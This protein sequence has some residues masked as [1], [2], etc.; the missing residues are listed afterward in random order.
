LLEIPGGWETNRSI[1]SFLQNTLINGRGLDYPGHYAS[2]I[3]SLT[4]DEVRN[5]AA[6]LVKPQ[7]LTWLIVGDRQKIEAGVRE[8][9]I[10]PLKILDKDGNEVK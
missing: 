2:V 6:S 9:N 5:A 10:G 4:L 1:R 3:Q 7:N 8:L